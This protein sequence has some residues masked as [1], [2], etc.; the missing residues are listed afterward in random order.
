MKNI[1]WFYFQINSVTYKD[2]L[3]YLNVLSSHILDKSK[4]IHF[5]PR[6]NFIVINQY[7][8][9]FSKSKIKTILKNMKEYF[10]E[11]YLKF[12]MNL[13]FVREIFY[14]LKYFRL[15]NLY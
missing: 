7:I 5:I 14:Q 6:N 10:L 9:L 11:I 15:L 13:N 8:K 1:F 2:L 4:F 3:F 12:N